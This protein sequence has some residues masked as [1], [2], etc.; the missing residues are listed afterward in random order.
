MKTD[1]WTIGYGHTEGVKKGDT[2]TREQADE[3][4]K[5]DLKKYSNYLKNV[6]VP[7]N[8]NE[9]I[10]LISFVYN[11][12]P[13]AFKSSTLLKKLNKG[14]KKG[15]AYEFDR[16]IY[17]KGKKLDGLVNRRKREKDLFLTPVE[18]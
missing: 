8:D 13:S 18:D 12:G 17:Q 10:A 5:N 3:L 2:I 14:D 11:V 7:L 16:W 1:V 4:F 9:K 15:A 6:S